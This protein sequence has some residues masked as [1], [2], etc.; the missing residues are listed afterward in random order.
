MARKRFILALLMCLTAL[1]G[2]AADVL[3]QLIS[4][5]DQYFN[6]RMMQHALACYQKAYADPSVKDSVNIKLHLLKSMMYSY[7]VTG[8]EFD[9]IETAYQLRTLAEENN[10]PAYVAMSDFMNGKHAHYQGRYEEGYALC[11]PALKQ[12]EQ[13]SYAQKDVE[14]CGFYAALTRMYMHDKHFDE[15]M[16]MSKKHEQVARRDTCD[17]L[18]CSLY[19]A[20]TIRTRLLSEAGRQDEADSC[21]AVSQQLGITDLVADHDLVSYLREKKRYNEMLEILQDAK[22]RLSADGDTLGILM[23]YMLKEQGKALY[24]LGRYQEAAQSYEQM[25]KVQVTMRRVNLELMGAAVRQTIANEQQLSHRNLSLS[26]L[27]AAIVILLLIAGGVIIHDRLQTRRNKAMTITIRR[28]MYYRDL[29]M[30]QQR[31]DPDEIAKNEQESEDDADQRRFV[32]MDRQVSQEELFRNANFGRDELMRLMGVDKNTLAT[33]INRYTGTNVT[34]YVNSKRMD[35]AVSLMKEHPE[36]SL[37]AI[38]E[39]CGINNA[40]TFIRNFKNAYDMTPS[41]FRKSLEELPP[42]NGQKDK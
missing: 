14:L 22:E 13:S 41:E 38:A 1:T 16:E 11:L 9:L 40:A 29:V 10:E 21:Y 27:I 35:Y 26:I 3:H 15:A 12:M 33:I 5:G 37:L 2:I 18:V 34:G 20:Y 17:N 36:Y 4:K 24:G 30:K 28:L 7:D 23:F 32:E 6:A 39:A 8:N 42:P 25:E 19:R 31:K